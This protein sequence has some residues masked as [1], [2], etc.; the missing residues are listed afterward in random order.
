MAN[1]E[2]IIASARLPETTVPLCMRGD[3]QAT[4]EELERELEEARAADDG[5]TLASGGRAREVAEQIEALRAEMSAHTHVFRFRALPRPTY[6]DLL[7]QHRPRKNRTDGGEDEIDVNLDTFPTSL[8]A[9]CCVDPPMSHEQ[10]SK[11]SAVVTNAQWDALFRG[12]FVV[13]RMTVDVPK[14]W[15]ASEILASTAPSSRPHEPG[16]SAEGGSSA[17]SLAG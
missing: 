8:I 16:G 13:N 14:S 17:G 9:A 3:L 12:A 5:G 6:S 15:A 1:I 4:F 11:L 7:A 2:D 10:A